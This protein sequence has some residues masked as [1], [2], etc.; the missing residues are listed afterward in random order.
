MTTDPNLPPDE[1]LRRHQLDRLAAAANI[2]L[3]R[4]EYHEALAALEQIIA[5]DPRQH[6]IHRAI[7]DIRLAHG[8][9]PDALAAY[10][11]AL[12][13]APGNLEYERCVAA[14]K[15]KVA[16]TEQTRKRVMDLADH[17]EARK[18]SPKRLAYAAG[19]ALVFPGLGQ[20]HN[21]DYVKGGVLAALGG[22]DLVCLIW[23]MVEFA[24]PK[25][26]GGDFSTGY[27]IA[28]LV[29]CGVMVGLIAYGVM[30][31]VAVARKQQTGGDDLTRV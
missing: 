24:L 25:V 11:R 14:A 15:L 13:L 8:K 16:E 5:L 26:R 19:A 21:G 23:M 29:A 3:R 31:A 17:P 2:H 28:A 20:L 30:D 10:E 7:G 1:A 12:E 9:A 27:G 18:V 4:Q 6:S 22:V